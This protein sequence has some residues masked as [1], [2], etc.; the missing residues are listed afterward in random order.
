[1]LTTAKCA[2]IL[3]ERE[4]KK[5]EIEDK[6]KRKAEREQKRKEKEDTAKKKAEEQARKAKEAAKKQENNAGIPDAD[7]GKEARDRL[8]SN[9]SR[10][11]SHY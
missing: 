5:K 3:E 8:R 7:P 4:Q 2:A 1:M 9:S 11:F 6:N 10:Y